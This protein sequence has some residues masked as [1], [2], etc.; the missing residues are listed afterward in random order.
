MK[1]WR[2]KRVA[3]M[4]GYPGNAK[5]RQYIRSSGPGVVRRGDERFYRSWGYCRFDR[6]QCGC[7]W[8]SAAA[9]KEKNGTL[10]ITLFLQKRGR[11]EESIDS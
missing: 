7:D 11:I 6:T 2:A 8:F 3:L 5:L 10:S 9:E 4:N 1:Y